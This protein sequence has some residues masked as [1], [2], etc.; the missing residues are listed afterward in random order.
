M[1]QYSGP[2]D[3]TAVGDAAVLAPYSSDE[4]DDIWECLFNS[5]RSG[6]EEFGVVAGYWNELEVTGAISPLAIDAG[7]ALV[8]GKWYR[9]TTPETLIVPN[10]TA[11]TRYDYVVLSCDWDGSAV[12][13]RP[14]T[15]RI[16]LHQGIEGA[17]APPALTQNDGSLWEIPLAIISTTV[18]GVITVYDDRHYIQSYLN[19]HKELGMGAAFL[20]GAGVSADMAYATQSAILEFDAI[21]DGWAQW[22]KDI[23]DWDEYHQIT[24][25]FK[26]LNVHVAPADGGDSRWRL[27]AS[28]WSD[29]GTAP[30]WPL[31]ITPEV[32]ASTGGA[33]AWEVVEIQFTIT[34]A[35]GARN[36]RILHLTL[37][38]D[39]TDILDTS[40]DTWVVVDGRIEYQS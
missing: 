31:Q 39:W 35:D 7:A 34:Y 11:L 9:N 20:D 38:R 22:E 36:H 32:T 12:P 13:A 3:G 14:Y 15:I 29:D 25:T 37:Y 5:G 28:Q 33:V 8:H 4:W 24:V 16:D 6:H 10:P 1:G 30:V 40:A 21:A 26:L 27:Y 23:S 18:G 17:G 2:W 19:R